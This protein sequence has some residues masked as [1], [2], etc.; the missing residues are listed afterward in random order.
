[1]PSPTLVPVECQSQPQ[2]QWYANPNPSL[3]GMPIVTPVTMVCQPQ[4]QSR[5][6]SPWYAKPNPS[7]SVNVMLIPNLV[8]MVYQSQSQS[9]W[10]VGPN[11][12]VSGM[13]IKYQS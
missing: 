2:S 11:L 3:N 1:M 12:C 8:S 9:Q 7:P 6:Q 10:Y 4:P 13:P 5:S